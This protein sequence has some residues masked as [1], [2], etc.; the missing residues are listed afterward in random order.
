MLKNVNEN[1]NWNNVGDSP[2]RPYVPSRIHLDAS[3]IFQKKIKL[4]RFNQKFY[5]NLFENRILLQNIKLEVL[6][7]KKNLRNS[8]KNV[9]VRSLIF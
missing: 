4:P 9:T 8:F 2:I 7:F 6:K 5:K 1:K 3:E